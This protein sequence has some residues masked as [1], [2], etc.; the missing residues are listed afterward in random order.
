VISSGREHAEIFAD[1]QGA[2]LG[3][4]VSGTERARNSNL[5]REP[6]LVADAA[7]RSL[8]GVFARR[9]STTPPQAI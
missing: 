2:I 6:E 8:E 5:L 7:F 4:D 9:A 3:A 1:A